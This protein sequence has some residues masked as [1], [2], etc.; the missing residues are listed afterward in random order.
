M[1]TRMP[2]GSRETLALVLLGK[3]IPFPAPLRKD[4]ETDLGYARAYAKRHGPADL[5]AL[6]IVEGVKRDYLALVC[7]KWVDSFECARKASDHAR[8]LLKADPQAQ[9]AYFVL[10]ITEY[11]IHR[12]PAILRV[13]TPIEGIDGDRK[14]A[15]GYCQDAI[16]SGHYFREFARRLLV[17]LYLDEGDRTRALREMKRLAAEYPG[18]T[19]IVKHLQ[20]MEAGA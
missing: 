11:M 17:D 4:L 10:A 12:V 20:K 18:N 2:G 14:K 15:M 5:L 13:F 7:Q 9:D 3:S 1:S 8:Q 16:K 6:A 19:G